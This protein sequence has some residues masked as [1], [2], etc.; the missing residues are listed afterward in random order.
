MLT[1]WGSQ[2]GSQ[3][4]PASGHI[5]PRPATVIA[6]RCHTGPRPATSS[7]GTNSPYKRGAAG[8]NPAAPT[9]LAGQM[10]ALINEMIVREPNGEPKLLMILAVAGLCEISRD[11]GRPHH[12]R[13][14]SPV[15]ARG[16]GTPSREGH[17]LLAGPA[18]GAGWPVPGIGVTWAVAAG[19]VAR[20]ARHSGSAY[21]D[22]RNAPEATGNSDVI[23]GLVTHE[24]RQLELAAGAASRRGNQP[25]AAYNDKAKRH[26]EAAAAGRAEHA[27]EV[28]VA[29]WQPRN[30]PT[31]A[32]PLDDFIGRAD[33]A[34][35][36]GRERQEWGEL[37]DE[38]HR[39]D[40]SRPNA[41][42]FRH[43][44]VNARFP[45][46]VT[47]GSSWSRACRRP[48]CRAG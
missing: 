26:E 37:V 7:D 19:N 39:V 1:K 43:L 16:G 22:Q 6:G 48:A 27:Y 32:V 34:P 38:G 36:L 18:R 41:M 40:R 21:Q 4:P 29:H 46:L 20:H 42:G 9:V 30:R 33:D 12:L 17:G 35:D 24:R 15:A 25:G 44:G 10:H 5:R 31:P 8:S 2:T 13:A 47:V 23:A 11:G 14:D 3:R 45:V 28:L